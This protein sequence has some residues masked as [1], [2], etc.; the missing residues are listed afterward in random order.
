MTLFLTKHNTYTYIWAEI[1]NIISLFDVAVFY[2]KNFII[3]PIFVVIFTHLSIAIEFG[4]SCSFIHTQKRDSF[5]NS[6]CASCSS[7]TTACIRAF[8]HTHTETRFIFK[9]SF[10]VYRHLRLEQSKYITDLFLCWAPLLLEI[11]LPA[12]KFEVNLR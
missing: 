11:K 6:I 8:I 12:G 7:S 9:Q 1:D 10:C 3:Y 2:S 4:K 5:W